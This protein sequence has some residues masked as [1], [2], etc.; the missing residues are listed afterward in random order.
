MGYS[1][2]IGKLGKNNAA[3]LGLL[4][5][6]SS[7]T[8]TPTRTGPASAVPAGP[9]PDSLFAQQ[10]LAYPAFEESADFLVLCDFESPRQL[11]H[12][13]ASANQPAPSHVTT[14]TATGQG[15]MAVDPTGRETQLVFQPNISRW[16]G[17]NLFLTAIHSG[18]DGAICRVE[19]QPL[20]GPARTRSY[21]L[22]RGWNK[23]QIDLVELFGPGGPGR[24]SKV[25][26]AFSSLADQPLHVDD[27]MLLDHRRYVLGAQEGH[28]GAMYAVKQGKYFRIGAHGRFELV[29]LNGRI[30]QWYDLSTDPQQQRNLAGR[31][32]LGPFIHDAPADAEQDVVSARNLVSAKKR[33]NAVRLETQVFFGTEPTTTRSPDQA[34]RYAVTDD[35][36]ID[37]ECDLDGE[38]AV[39]AFE[40]AAD[41]GFEAVEGKVRTT[42]GNAEAVVEYVLLRRMGEQRGADLLASLRPW[43]AAHLPVDAATRLEDGRLIVEFRSEPAG[44]RTRVTGMLRVWPENLDHLGNAEPHVRSFVNRVP[45]VPGGSETT[46]DGANWS[47]AW[48]G[49][50]DKPSAEPELE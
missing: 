8:Q 32:G 40:T 13:D 6:L 48:E 4:T 2:T 38:A 10:T 19:F 34:W 39:L 46:H 3:L 5:L 42:A 49:R 41:A 26:Y 44:G 37:L 50:Q 33:L 24:M 23:L 11:Q 35:G 21:L 36:R 7:C 12:F 16:E 14:P 17:Y 43:K 45:L 22:Q 47:P 20:D 28:E 18:S 29:F 1:N 25:V 9:A 31:R 15:A 27:I 30:D